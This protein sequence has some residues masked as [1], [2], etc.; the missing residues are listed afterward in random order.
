MK[1]GE[2]LALLIYLK[3]ANRNKMRKMAWASKKKK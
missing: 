1:K 3:K 2:N